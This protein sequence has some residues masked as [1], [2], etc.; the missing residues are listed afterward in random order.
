MTEN[1]V[2]T[3]LLADAHQHRVHNQS[4][5][6]VGLRTNPTTSLT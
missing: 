6:R 2:T 3:V 4:L 1:S 5:V